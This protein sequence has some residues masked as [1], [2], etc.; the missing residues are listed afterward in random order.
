LTRRLTRSPY[1][2]LFR[3]K[4]DGLFV[5]KP[6]QVEAF[7]TPLPVAKIPGVG[8]VMQGKLEQLGIATVGDLRAFA[9]EELRQR[10]GSFGAALYQ[11]R[12][13]TRLNSSHVK[14]S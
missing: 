12:K 8:K 5:V 11:D 6:A 4:P 9:Q 7:L 1:T 2:T 3:S 10:F 14:I 13:S